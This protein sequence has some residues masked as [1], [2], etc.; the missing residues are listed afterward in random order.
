[1]QPT[2]EDYEKIPVDKFGLALLR[3]M[4]WKPGEGIGRNK[5]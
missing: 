3:G 5:Q 2:D 4:G 1:L